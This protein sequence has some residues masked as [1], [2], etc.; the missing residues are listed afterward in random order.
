M[1]ER[2]AAWAFV[3]PETWPRPTP[4]PC[5][6]NSASWRNRPR[7]AR[8]VLPGT[9][10]RHP[11]SSR[12]SAAHACSVIACVTSP[13]SAKPSPPTPPAPAKSCALNTPC[14]NACASASAPACS[15]PDEPRLAKGIVCELPYPT[16]NTRYITRA[17]IAGL[18]LIY[19][20]G[21][22][23]SKAELLLMDL[24][25]RGEYTDDLSPK[26]KP[27]P[28]SGS[29]ACS[30]RSMRSGGGIRSDRAELLQCRIGAY[31]GR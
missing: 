22:A 26:P 6:S 8:H 10:R 24:C 18:E 30:M 2:S 25:Q 19:R 1:T 12:K 27:R 29:W 14:A 3:A 16:D 5:A 4:G 15:T 7:T 17:A 11:R 20:E 31:G 13:R 23:F 21:F 28:R 9:G